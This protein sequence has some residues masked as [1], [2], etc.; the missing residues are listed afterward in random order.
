MTP[1]FRWIEAVYGCPQPGVDGRTHIGVPEIARSALMEMTTELV[2]SKGLVALYVPLG[3]EAIY[4]PGTKLGRIIAAVELLAMPD[5][6]KVEDYFYPDW[7]G[8]RRWPIGWPARLIYAPPES[9]CPS[10]REHVETLFGPGS[11][12]AYTSR[13]QKGPFRLEDALRERLNRDF[14]EFERLT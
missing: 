11:F 12:S 7:D 1:D 13:F 3:T 5:G 9:A 10:L 4:N 2:G 14:A 6:G 8:S